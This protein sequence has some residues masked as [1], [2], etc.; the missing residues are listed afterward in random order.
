MAVYWWDSRL[1]CPQVRELEKQ[2]GQRQTRTSSPGSDLS[3]NLDPRKLTAQEK[4]LLK[5]RT[6]EREK[7]ESL[8]VRQAEH[9]GAGG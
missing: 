7:Q 9:R 3:V 1:Y 2:L 8:E 4:N 5:L 6:L